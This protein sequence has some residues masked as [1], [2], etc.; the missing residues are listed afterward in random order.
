[1]LKKIKQI[2]YSIEDLKSKI[3]K[4]DEVIKK[5]NKNE[6]IKIYSKGSG[7]TID[8]HLRKSIIGILNF[9]KD[10]YN[11]RIKILN[12]KLKETIKED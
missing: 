8:S 4:V 5:I 2:I 6:E 9:Q 12:Q 3:D 1:M 7:A 11:H 10:T